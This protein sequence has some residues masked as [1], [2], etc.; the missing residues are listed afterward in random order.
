MTHYT[1]SE[2][3]QHIATFGILYKLPESI[4]TLL[5]KLEACLEITDS[6]PNT[7]HHHS[8]SSQGRYN[9]V[10]K[11]G[12]F[13]DNFRHKRPQ[14]GRLSSGSGFAS[15][16]SAQR[17][18]K[19]HSSGHSLTESA[20][21]RSNA[22]TTSV[23]NDVEWELMR[24]FKATK[25]DT[26]TGIEKTVNDIR[27]ALNKMSVGNYDKQKNA[28]LECVGSYFSGEDA[29]INDDDTR[30]I[31]KAIFDIASTNKFYSEIYARLYK[32]LVDVNPVFRNLLDEF[33]A[34]FT[35]M[36]N[37]AIYVDPD[38]DYDGFCAYS[39]VCDTRKS[40]STFLVNCLKFDLILPDQLVN[41]LCD[42][43]Y[44]VETHINDA[45]FSKLIEEVIENI[46]IIATMCCKELAHTG[47]WKGVVL[48]SIRGFAGHK[49]DGCLG[50]SSRATFKCMD[51]IAKI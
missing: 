38:I 51:L 34:G 31:S 19:D 35:N 48:P 3:M 2:L 45:E 13:T 42:F 47:K 10:G 33:V 27:V 29:N 8:A 21:R 43:V 6:L 1:V 7:Q 32:E 4:T 41:I 36:D 39:K 17:N 44:Y 16:A 24:S 40:T 15:S 12:E 26:K 22:A 30:R 50:L 20:G 9:S 49:K 25:I 28:I 23:T 14:D 18:K 5:V 11:S 37:A 46:Y